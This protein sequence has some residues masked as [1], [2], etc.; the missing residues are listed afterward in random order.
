MSPFQLF[1]HKNVSPG[2][3]GNFGRAAGVGVFP[4]FQWAPIWACWIA[5]GEGL[6]LLILTLATPGKK[7]CCPRVSF[8]G[9]SVLSFL[10]PKKYTDHKK[11]RTLRFLFPKFLGVPTTFVRQTELDFLKC[12]L[13]GLLLIF[14]L[15][16]RLWKSRAGFLPRKILKKFKLILF[17]GAAFLYKD[18]LYRGGGCSFF[19]M[20]VSMFDVS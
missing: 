7:Q 8:L 5:A 13:G 6:L 16:F 18:F 11:A 19:M 20:R 4:A 1:A 14:W 10:I 12:S 9:W 3:F 2:C 17:Q 15:F